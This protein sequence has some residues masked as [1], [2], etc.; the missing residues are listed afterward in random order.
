MTD[1][2]L[3]I[4]GTER[5]GSNL[6]RLILNTHP[7]IAVPHPPHVV[8]FF[9]PLEPAYGDLAGSDR[10]FAALVDDVLAFV[11]WHIYPWEVRIDRGRVLREASP[12]DSFG[13]TVALY[14]QYR[15]H[16]GKARWGCKSTFMI[17]HVGR[18]LDRYPDARL[19]YLT[20][21]PRDVAVSSRRSVFNPFHPYFTARLWA[22]QQR[23]GLGLLRTLPP[24]TI[25]HLRYEALVREPARTVADLCAFLGEP[26]DERMLRYFETPEAARSASLSR[27]WE[28]TGKAVLSSNCGKYRGEL[29]PA[30]L[31]AVESVAR[32]EM[33][34]L[35]YPPDL[36]PADPPSPLAVAGYRLLDWWGWLRVEC[37]SLFFDRNHWL[38]WRRDLALLYFRAR[39]RSHPPRRGGSHDRGA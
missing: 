22:S 38:R 24:R 30:E 25:F 39:R 12:R 14:D 37:G 1:N 20:R 35:G 11:R 10:A 13:I 7:R 31:R 18:V 19:I 27:S 15:D 8:R 23:T 6:L 17:D 33:E 28:N 2:P 36:P 16:A 34:Q 26:F 5:S 4:L 9:A 3:F 29:S 32:D 21:D